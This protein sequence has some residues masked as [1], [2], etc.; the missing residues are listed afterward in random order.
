MTA[1]KKHEAQFAKAIKEL[2]DTEPIRPQPDARIE[3]ALSDYTKGLALDS[4]SA[5]CDPRKPPPSR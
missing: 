4:L 3:K 1:K 5:N 2:S